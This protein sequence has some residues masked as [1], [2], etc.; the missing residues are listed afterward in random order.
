M[1]STPDLTHSIP[2]RLV[3]Q[4]LPAP[5]NPL[6]RDETVERIPELLR[7]DAQSDLVRGVRPSEALSRDVRKFRAHVSILG[8]NL[9]CAIDNIKFFRNGAVVINRVDRHRVQ[10]AIDQSLSD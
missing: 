4:G 8:K 10:P 5:E 6:R 1:W 9:M 3:Q 7:E 2:S